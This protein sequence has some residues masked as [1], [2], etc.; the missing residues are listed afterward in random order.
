MRPNQLLVLILT[1]LSVGVHAE[2][3]KFASNVQVT[4]PNG[5]EHALEDEGKTIVIQSPK[6][7]LFELRLTFYSL[8][9]YIAQQPTV[10]ADFVADAAKKAG[11]QVSR[12]KGTTVTGFVEPGSS[13]L[14][15]GQRFRSMHGIFVV[16]P[17]YATMTLISTEKNADDPTLR[18]FV[19]SGMEKILATL[20]YVGT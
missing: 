1:L 12:L 7:G 9:A 18:A 10:A 3:V 15:G 19:G 5:Y 11:R 6:P 2:T 20:R 17:G 4:V 13:T 14:V 16:G 8:S